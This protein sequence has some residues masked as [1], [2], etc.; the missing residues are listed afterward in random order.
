LFLLLIVILTVRGTPAL[1]LT[2]LEVTKLEGV[3]VGKGPSVSVGATVHEPEEEP[4]PGVE[5]EP[6]VVA[7]VPAT[8]VSFLQAVYKGATNAT[9]KAAIQF[10][11]KSLRCIIGLLICFI[12]DDKETKNG[13][14]KILNSDEMNDCCGQ[15]VNYAFYKCFIK[16]FLNTYSLLVLIK[17]RNS[18]I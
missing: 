6:D 2:I 7:A 8:S 15:R 12:T 1:S 17:T 10:F 3:F 4:E 9:P 13:W 14:V 5:P 16:P 18:V 11:K